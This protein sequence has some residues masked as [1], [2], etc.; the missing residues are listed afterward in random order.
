MQLTQCASGT[1]A[2]LV[3]QFRRLVDITT[4]DIVLL[5]ARNIY[6]HIWQ[7][8]QRCVGIWVVNADVVEIV[9]LRI[10]LGD[11][12]EI[13]SCRG[14]LGSCSDIVLCGSKQRAIDSLQ[15]TCLAVELF[16]QFRLGIELYA[17]VI[18][19]M[20]SVVGTY[21][22]VA[23]RFVI[24]TLG[25]DAVSISGLPI[26]CP[27]FDVKRGIAIEYALRGFCRCVYCSV[28]VMDG[29]ASHII[30]TERLFLDD[31]PSLEIAVV[32]GRAL[33]NLEGEG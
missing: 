30:S 29:N 9:L 8:P 33:G 18:V 12:I 6:R 27:H 24:K 2:T 7:I 14:I 10:S 11:G 20:H 19:L 16:V 21:K 17:T 3:L 5:L 4:G 13:Y 22:I 28:G 32:D 31:K 25:A 1:L 15:P 23:F 26:A